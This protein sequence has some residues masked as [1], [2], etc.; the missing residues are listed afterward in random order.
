MTRRMIAAMAAVALT[1]GCSAAP[2]ASVS[3]PGPTASIS[4]PSDAVTLA[5]LLLNH[6]PTDFL[7]PK[8]TAVTS[9][10]DQPNVVTLT[11][12]SSRRKPLA[13]WLATRLPGGWQ[14][15]ANANDSL[16]FHSAAWQGA[17]T[18][19]TTECALTLRKQAS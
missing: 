13:G 6:G 15:D 8:G 2:Q 17:F 5:D 14:I 19:S 3:T 1:A 7:L 10:I 4:V 16:L 12:D 11:F 18:C 9:R